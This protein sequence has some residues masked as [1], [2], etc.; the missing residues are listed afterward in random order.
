MNVDVSVFRTFTIYSMFNIFYS[1]VLKLVLEKLY[2]DK[3]NKKANL[4]SIIINIINLILIITLA[5]ITKNQ[6]ITSIGTIIVMG[7]VLF[8]ILFSNI[9]KFKFN[10]S[11]IDNI[12]NSSIG[13]VEN[14]SMFII[15]F[16]GH[17]NS[18]SFGMKYILAS[19]FIG[20]VSD[21]Q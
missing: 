8:V 2:Y 21:T 7:I 17:I 5:L 1:Y 16:F 20:I 11:I 12:K 14:I 15:C 19:T 18:Y 4:I 13:I 6:H 9:K 3:Q 10:I